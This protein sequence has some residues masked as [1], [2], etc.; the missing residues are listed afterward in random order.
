MVVAEFNVKGLGGG[1]NV[2]PTLSAVG[3]AE[4]FTSGDPLEMRLTAL[5]EYSAVLS[6]FIRMLAQSKPCWQRF[7]SSRSVSSVFVGSS[8]GGT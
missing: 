7:D 3:S 2:P 1:D 8:A 4:T 6:L 5:A